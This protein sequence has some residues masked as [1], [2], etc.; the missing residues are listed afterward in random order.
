MAVR[1]PVFYTPKTT[2]RQFDNFFCHWWHRKLSKWQ[3]TMPTVMTKFSTL[4]WRH[5]EPDSVSNHQPHDCFLNRLFR[6]RSKNTSKLRVTGLCAEIHR[7]PVNSARKYPVTRKMLQFD[8]VIM[9]QRRQN[10]QIG[11]RLFSVYAFNPDSYLYYQILWH[12]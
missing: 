9:Q 1:W 10:C 8:D 7:S 3:F 4:Q 2:G 6:G 12:N 11:D 5:N